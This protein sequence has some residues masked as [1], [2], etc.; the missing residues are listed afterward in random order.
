MYNHVMKPKKGQV[1][2]VSWW[3][4]SLTKRRMYAAKKA[5]QMERASELREKRRTMYLNLRREYKTEIGKA[6][7]ES[8]QGFVTIEGNA[9]H[10]T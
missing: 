7:R 3:T 6:R 1:K 9:T 5:F 8:W 4:E 2:S 10:G